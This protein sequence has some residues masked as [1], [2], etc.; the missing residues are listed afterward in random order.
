MH[1]M[2][3]N[4]LLHVGCQSCVLIAH[5]MSEWPIVNMQETEPHETDLRA[6]RGLFL[7]GILMA[8]MGLMNAFN[9][10]GTVVAKR[11]GALHKLNLG[12]KKQS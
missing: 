2:I 9:T 1:R 6:L 10:I 11:S 5:I 3:Q 7:V 8:G 4:P 12:G